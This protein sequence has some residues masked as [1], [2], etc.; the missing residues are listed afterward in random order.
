[1]TKCD[2]PAWLEVLQ[3][4]A[5][6]ILTH[7]WRLPQIIQDF[8]NPSNQNPQITLF[9][10]RRLKEKALRKLCDSNYKGQRRKSAINIRADN[11]SLHSAKPKLFADCDPTSK[12]LERACVVPQTCHQDHTLS[13]RSL[14]YEVHDLVFCRLIFMFVDVICIF[15]DDLG[16]LGAV[17]DMILDWGHISSGSSTTPAIRPRVIVVVNHAQ[18]ITH[19]I[20]DEKNFLY[21]LY[22]KEPALSLSFADIRFSRL[23]SDELKSGRFLS[24][25]ADI[26]RQL[27]EASFA[28]VKENV[29]FSAT[30]LCDLF[31]SA[32]ESLCQ[33]PSA[34]TEFNFIAAARAQN[35][36]DGSFTSHL[37]DFIILAGKSRL[38]YEGVSSHIASA[39]LMDA[40]PP[41]MHCEYSSFS[42]SKT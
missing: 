29:L 13:F 7:G 34:L 32:A 18:S 8:P 39:I 21:D 35:P 42:P 24:L 17:E 10:G 20:L 19:D 14:P 23:P 33:S 12:G 37:K 31:K 30:H 6:P 1:M 40:Y 22:M 9:M 3:G 11:R 16:G 36:L 38:P 25:G 2:H 27:H 5:G 28:R 15:A 41:G 26:T 4:E